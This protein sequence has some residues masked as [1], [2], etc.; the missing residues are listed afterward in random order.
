MEKQT[1][2][3]KIVTKGEKCEMSDAEIKKWYEE[4]IA[5]LFNHAYGTPEI[6]V[7]VKREIK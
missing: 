7:D 1:V 2:T 3:V 5:K 4:N 6:T